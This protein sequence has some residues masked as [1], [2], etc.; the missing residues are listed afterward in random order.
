MEIFTVFG[1]KNLKVS[2]SQG[3]FPIDWSISYNDIKLSTIFFNAQHNL[4]LQEM[5]QNILKMKD[6]VKEM[7][8]FYL[9]IKWNF[10]SFIPFLNF[11]T[12]QDTFKIWKIGHQIRMDCG[13]VGMKNLK[14]KKR[15][16]SLFLNLKGFEGT[17]I[18]VNHDKKCFFDTL[19]EL[20]QEEKMYL[21]GDLVHS[22]I[23]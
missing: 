10:E 20:D 16:V 8:D 7:A 9:E 18:Y 21:I 15:K 17:V 19:E 14:A 12:P 1:G 13:I 11:F 3:W 2:D 23:S 4:K 6:Y 5:K 22:K